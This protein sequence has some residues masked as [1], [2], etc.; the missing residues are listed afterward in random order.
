[1]LRRSIAQSGRRPPRKLAHPA[2]GI[3]W[4]RPDR[5]LSRNAFTIVM[6]WREHPWQLYTET[7][8]T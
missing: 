5:V 7:L 4:L 3:E 1:M 8:L 6:V 2:A